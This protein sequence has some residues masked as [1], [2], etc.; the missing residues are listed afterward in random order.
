MQV[1]LLEG[2]DCSG[3]KTVARKTQELLA[4]RGVQAKLVVGPLVE[5]SLGKVDSQVSNLSRAVGG[6]SPIGLVRR[7]VYV[8]GP[9]V[10]GLVC[11]RSGPPRVIKIS[12]HYRAW[13]RAI[14]QRDLP[15]DWAFRATRWSH[16]PLVGAT[17]LRTQ[18]D[19]RIARHSEDVAAGRTSKDLARRF[20][21]PDR[22]AFDRWDAAL[23]TLLKK[24]VADLQELDTSRTGVQDLAESVA[25]HALRCWR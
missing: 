17:F 8:V 7:F 23:A 4:R 15:M 6:T 22:T 24:A 9:V 2:L 3:K 25:G 20:L 11:R 1:Y 16:L 21:G 13:A 12:S 18:F 14:T 5:G 10:D 19:V